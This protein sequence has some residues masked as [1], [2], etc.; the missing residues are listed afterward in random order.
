[1]QIFGHFKP[2]MDIMHN[3]QNRQLLTFGNFTHFQIMIF[4]IKCMF[5][6]KM[7]VMF[8]NSNLQNTHIFIIFV[9]EYTGEA[10]LT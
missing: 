5:D 8:G 10:M 3:L 9:Y 1:M 7:V 6:C 2:I 4:T